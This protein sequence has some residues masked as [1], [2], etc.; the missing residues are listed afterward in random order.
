[1][2]MHPPKRIYSIVLA[3]ALLFVSLITIG[4]KR[5]IA[6]DESTGPQTSG[7]GIVLETE[8]IDPKCLHVPLLGE[9]DSTEAEQTELIDEQDPMT[10][11]TALHTS[12]E[13]EIGTMIVYDE[14]KL[15]ARIKAL[16]I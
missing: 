13:H 16:A 2:L 4:F 10:W 12:A 3:F 15:N 6:E 14:A 8:D 9:I 5:T 11:I 7:H 1:M